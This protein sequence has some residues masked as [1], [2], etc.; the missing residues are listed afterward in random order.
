[1][2]TPLLLTALRDHLVANGVGRLPEAGGAL[3]PIWREPKLGLPAP[4][5]TPP[6]GN[7]NEAGVDSV[8]GLYTSSGIP[9]PPY[10]GFVR[11]PIVDVRLRVARADIAE[12]LE[13]A[14]TPLIADRRGF[15]MGGLYVIECE[16]W[17]ALSRLGSGPQG[18]EFTT[19]YTFELYR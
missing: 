13:L 18:F 14:I 5:E 12:A 15:T 19:A 8:I 10:Y 1:M 17:R 11:R 6:K 9:S 3:P 4:G 7:A 2:A 16:Q